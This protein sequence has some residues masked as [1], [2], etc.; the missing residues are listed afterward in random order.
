MKLFLNK[1][2]IKK[3]K[4]P[5]PTLK[6]AWFGPLS[7]KKKDLRKGFIERIPLL[8]SLNSRRII[9][10]M[11]VEAA[12]LLPIVMFFFLHI[13]G[14]VE[15]LRLH[16]KLC[17]ALWEC[18][19]QLTMYSAMPGELE[20]KIPDIAISYLYV[21]GR[22]KAF[23]GKEYL[24]NSPIVQGGRGLNYLSSSY[25][26]DCIDIAVTYQVSPPISLFPFGYMRMV[27]RYYG[28]SWTGFDPEEELKYVYVTLYGEVWHETAECTYITINV[29]DTARGNI[30]WLRNAAGKNYTACELCRD[31]P[32]SETV[33]YT[34]QGTR[35]HNSAECPSLTRYVSAILWQEELPYRPCSRCVG[36]E[37]GK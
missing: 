6:R 14:A 21:E 22:V 10:S 20:E 16:G 5:S 4:T 30:R 8:S 9:A 32:A 36:K 1:N 12:V 17:F 23:L 24:E 2:N 29:Q 26:E 33:Y 27:N 25:E 13:M 34:P 15:M 11:T 7:R 3:I 28:R 35:F 37:E 19:N 31:E 18:G